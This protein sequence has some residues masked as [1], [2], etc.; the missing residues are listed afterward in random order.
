MLSAL[1]LMLIVTGTTTVSFV[2][3]LLTVT[4]PEYVP[5]GIPEG[6][7][8]TARDPRADGLSVPVVGET[9]NQDPPVIVET[10]AVKSS[11]SAPSFDT[12]TILTSA[13]DPC[14]KLKIKT[15]WGHHELLLCTRITNQWAS[16]KALCGQRIPHGSVVKLVGHEKRVLT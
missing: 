8:T 4:R 2:V 7:A 14:T 5:D 1:P 15:V 11:W 16:P 9:A 13:F 6:E 12:V 10:E 3:G